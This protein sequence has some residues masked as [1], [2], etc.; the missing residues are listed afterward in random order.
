MHTLMSNQQYYEALASSTIV[1]KQ[2]LNSVI[3]CTQ[4]KPVPDEQPNDTDVE[5]T[6]RRIKQNDPELVEVNLN[7]IKN[8]PIS[9]L[10]AYAEALKTNTVVERLSIVGTRSNDPVAHCSTIG[11]RLHHAGLPAHRPLPRL[12]LTPRHRHQ[13]LQWCRTRLSWSDS[14]WQRVIFSDESRFSLGGDAQRNHRVLGGT[15]VLPPQHAVNNRNGFWWKA[16]G[17]PSTSTPTVTPICRNLFV[18]MFKLHGMGQTHSGLCVQ[19]GA[20]TLRSLNVESNFITGAGILALV[21]ALQHN[22]ILQELKIDNQSQPLGNKV[23][24]EIASM[25]EKNSTLLKFGYHFT[26][27]GPRLRCSNAMMNNNDLVRVVRTDSDG[28]ITFTL[29]VPELERAFCKKFQ[30]SSKPNLSASLARSLARSLS[31]SAA[32]G[33]LPPALSLGREDLKVAP[34]SLN[35]GQTCSSCGSSGDGAPLWPGGLRQ[36][37]S[38]LSGLSFFSPRPLY[39]VLQASVASCC[40]TVHHCRDPTTT[41]PVRPSRPQYRTRTPAALLPLEFEAQDAGSVT[42]MIIRIFKE[43]GAFD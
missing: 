32:S 6:L 31:R 34:S 15:V 39:F 2:G 16:P 35:V 13:R 18:R 25:L 14:E 41:T 20:T 12:S 11:R 4:Y 8:I 26:Q 23:E 19:R 29:S 43:G 10:K 21:A 17:C 30:F 7:N 28:A 9:T 38:L 33:V 27:Q 37:S 42:Y 3:Q 24:M 36:P 40:L 22:T 5:E 1:N